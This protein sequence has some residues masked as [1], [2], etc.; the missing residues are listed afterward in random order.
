M[1]RELALHSTKPQ[2]ISD[3]NAELH[4]RSPVYGASTLAEFNLVGQILEVARLIE[5]GDFISLSVTP[6]WLR[7]QTQPKLYGLH[8]FRL[9]GDTQAPI[10]WNY[11]DLIDV[12]SQKGS[13][14][15]QLKNRHLAS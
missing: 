5:L 7:L 3:N 13:K 9:G 12:G 6:T 15:I 14:E 10:T 8:P 2:E 1:W 11:R 4:V